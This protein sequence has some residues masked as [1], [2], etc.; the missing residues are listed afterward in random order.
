MDLDI[1]AIFDECQYEIANNYQ[2]GENH[3][4]L[5]QQT[6][7]NIAALKMLNDDSIEETVKN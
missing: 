4:K 5:F 6:I 3:Q 7:S 2:M 1:K